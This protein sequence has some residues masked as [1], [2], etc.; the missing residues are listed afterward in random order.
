[1]K[2]ELCLNRLKWKTFFLIFVILF[3]A[4]PLLASLVGLTEA[5][6]EMEV[7]V[8]D[9]GAQGNGHSD[10]REAIQNAILYAFNNNIT[11]V[12]IPTGRYLIR[13]RYIAIPSNITLIGDES[14]ESVLVQ[15]EATYVMLRNQDSTNGNSSIKLKN[16]VI[17]GNNLEGGLADGS[18]HGNGGIRFFNSKDIT[19]DN[20]VV[21]DFYARELKPIGNR[22][23]TM[24]SPVWF[25]NCE[26]VN[27]SNCS[28]INAGYSGITFSKSVRNVKIV[29]S[30][31][32][33]MHNNAVRMNGDG[34]YPAW[35]GVFCQNILIEGNTVK[36][37]GGSSLSGDGAF[38]INLADGVKIINNYFYNCGE[39][40][41]GK[42]WGSS[43]QVRQSS[44]VLIDNN[45]VVVDGIAVYDGI[46][47]SPL[48]TWDCLWVGGFNSKHLSDSI[49]I[50]RNEVIVKNNGRVDKRGIGNRF[51]G[52][53]ITINGNTV[54]V[55]ATSF[56]ERAYFLA[57]DNITFTNNTLINTGD[58]PI[59]IYEEVAD[60]YYGLGAATNIYAE[61]NK[62]VK[63]PETTP[64]QNQNSL[65]LEVSIEGHGDIHPAP[66]I[67]E[68]E[69]GSMI[70]LTAVSH[71]G[72]RFKEW[73]GA[74]EDPFSASTTI[75]LNEPIKVT[76]LFE[77]EPEQE[78]QPTTYNLQISVIGGGSVRT[79][80]K[81]TQYEEGT[82]LDITAIPD[83]GW[84]F[85]EWKGDVVNTHSTNTNIIIDSDKTIQAIFEKEPAP[86]QQHTLKM[87]VEGQG[88]TNPNPGLYKYEKG[89]IV[90]LQAIPDT[91]WRFVRWEGAVSKPT[92]VTTTILIE[93]DQTVNAVFEA[94]PRFT[95]NIWRSS[96]FRERQQILNFYWNRFNR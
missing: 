57:G 85:K 88:K 45:N 80:S 30:S 58:V 39:T 33:G 17:D 5:S 86:A 43:I 32:N 49:V 55:D 34:S 73:L 78:Y 15:H 64:E 42:H 63:L 84:Q 31:F 76:A 90:N 28:F 94:V 21:R 25:D 72:W 27:I 79:G 9:F 54:N 91:G 51:G 62:L 16:I 52:K 6:L 14:G 89:S 12:R 20:V 83:Q 41:N 13:E 59:F 3:S 50:T 40:I 2:K 66:G 10:D 24:Y 35:D 93:H 71:S 81:S 60:D 37:I 96:N 23:T 18:N 56:L 95:P 11:Y 38:D 44:N 22:K 68:Y 75:L 74:V 77:A 8:K 4:I 69:K 36:N 47:T 82:V 7:N 53:N 65:T 26:N 70:N 48:Y 61:N 46:R 92:S 67:Y 29:S 87:T 1:M 19:L